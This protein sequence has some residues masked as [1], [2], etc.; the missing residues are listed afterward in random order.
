MSTKKTAKK[1]PAVK[2]TRAIK[3]AFEQAL[4]ATPVPTPVVT[5][6]QQIIEADDFD[7]HAPRGKQTSGWQT[8]PATKEEETEI[9]ETPEQYAM[10]QA[11][12]EPITVESPI[13]KPPIALQGVQT[14]SVALDSIFTVETLQQLI[15]AVQFLGKKAKAMLPKDREIIQKRLDRA[16]KLVRHINTQ[17][18]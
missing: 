4:E 3:D 10:K 17:V 16:R 14:D 12:D 13:N 7:E 9:A 6:E 8:A 11:P 18:K 5:N 2:I 1:K 15:D